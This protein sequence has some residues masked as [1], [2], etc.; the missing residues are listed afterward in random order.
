MTDHKK[1]TISQSAKI[2]TIS[3]STLRRWMKQGKIASTTDT[4]GTHFFDEC[5]LKKMSG[6]IP[7]PL[8][9]NPPSQTY[10]PPSQAAATIGISKS[11][12][13]RYEQAGLITP[14]RTAQGTRRYRIKDL[15]KLARSHTPYQ[16]KPRLF[17]YKKRSGYA[18]SSTDPPDPLPGTTGSF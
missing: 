2:L 5:V 3:K 7:K 4:N 17:P 15:K 1:Y 10:L 14:A 6:T 18:G 12:L 16:Q 11:T 8:P 9:T 13:L